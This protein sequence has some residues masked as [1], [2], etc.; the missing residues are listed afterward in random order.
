MERVMIQNNL[1]MYCIYDVL[2]LHHLAFVNLK[3]SSALAES[4]MYSS[5]EVAQGNVLQLYVDLFAFKTCTLS[6]NFRM[7][8]PFD[9]LKV[10]ESNTAVL[11]RLNQYE[12]LYDAF[13][14]KYNFVFE[15]YL[16]QKLYNEMYKTQL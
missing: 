9:L 12:L 4:D 3:N 8:P 6:F 7:F 1:L 2:N 14:N 16:K 5:C 11:K 15:N 13:V 10:L